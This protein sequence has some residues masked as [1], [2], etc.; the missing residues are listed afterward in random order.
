MYMKIYMYYVIYEHAEKYI[1]YEIDIHEI[2]RCSVKSVSGDI[3]VL[4][5]IFT[6]DVHVSCSIFTWIYKCI[7]LYIH[8]KIY[9]KLYMYYVIYL[10]EDIHV[11]CN[12]LTWK[13]TCIMNYICMK[14]YNINNPINLYH[15]LRTIYYAL[16][17]RY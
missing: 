4:C 13:D 14:L 8:M 16:D 1:Y 5:D 15:I 7:M 17:T 6:C 12:I 11:W 2:C 9:I 3:C 10:H